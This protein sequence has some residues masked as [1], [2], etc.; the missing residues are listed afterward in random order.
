MISEAGREGGVEGA[1]GASEPSGM[2]W[3]PDL[4]RC[5]SARTEYLLFQQDGVEL[6]MCKI[7]VDPPSNA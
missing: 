2:F 3:G 6:I 7:G 5:K 1:G 4:G